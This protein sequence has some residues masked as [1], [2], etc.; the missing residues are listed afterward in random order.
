MTKSEKIGL[1]ALVAL[2]ALLVVL[3]VQSCRGPSHPAKDSVIIQ[4][5]MINI[6]KGE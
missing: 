5:R 2:F 4:Q 3:V 1:G 6:Q